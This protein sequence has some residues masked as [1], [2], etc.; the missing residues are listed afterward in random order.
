M[1]HPGF[2]GQSRPQSGGGQRSI[3]V[4]VRS[5]AV[6][7][8][9]APDQVIAAGRMPHGARRVGRVEKRGSNARAGQGVERGLE[10]GQLPR[11]IR[12]VDLVGDG[13]VGPETLQSEM[14][15]AGHGPRPGPRPASASAPDPVH[16]R[17][18]FH[19]YG[20][21]PIGAGRPEPPSGKASRPAGV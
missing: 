4:G 9:P 3:P 6:Q 15:V 16:P 20:A 12:V 21:A 18:H 8:D 14:A 2:E 1:R 7:G 17:V 13:Q 19:V 10:A 11:G 5:Q